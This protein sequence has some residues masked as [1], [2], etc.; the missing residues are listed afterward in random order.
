MTTK[1]NEFVLRRTFNARRPIV[2]N[3]WTDSQRLMQWWGPKGFKTV[4]CKLDLRPGGTFLYGLETPDGKEM[5]GRWAIREVVEPEKL[6]FVVSFSNAEGGITRHPW[7]ADW[8]LQTRSTVSFDDASDQTA[9]TIRW[10]PHEATESECKTFDG[11]HDSMLQ[12]WTGTFDQLEAYLA[13]ASR[14]EQRAEERIQ[15]SCR[16]TL[17]LDGHKAPCEIQN[18]CTRGFLIR[19]DKSLPVGGTLELSCDLDATRS[20]HCTVQVRHVNRQCLGAKVIDITDEEQRI[21]HEF[22]AERRAAR[23]GS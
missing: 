1:S 6:D 2:W 23:S 12:G 4:S 16:G 22:I 7:N 10:S 15:V 11:S 18:M 9:V 8:P 17:A 13:R 20:I 19:A 5:W 14:I 3:A 21:C